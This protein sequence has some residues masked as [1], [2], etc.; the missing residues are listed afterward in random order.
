MRKSRQ[1][2]PR[3]WP[4]DRIQEVIKHYE[5]QTGKEAAAEMEQAI[6]S[7]E[8]RLMQVPISLVDDVRKLIMSR[9][10]KRN[11]NVRMVR[12]STK[13]YAQPKRKK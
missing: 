6:A 1:R 2:L 4:Q 10:A 11:A 3:G 7:G 8:F 5:G 13:P 9:L 12:E